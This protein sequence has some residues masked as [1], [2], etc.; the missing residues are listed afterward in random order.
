MNRLL[1]RNIVFTV[2]FLS[3]LVGLI[4]LR[5]RTPFGKDNS[6]FVSRPDEGITRIEITGGKNRLV[7]ESSEDGWIVNNNGQA[8]Q[9]AIHFINSILTTLRIKSTVSDDYFEAEIR[10]KKLEPVRVR[11]FEKRRVLSS[12]IVYKTSSNVYGNIMKISERAKP[13]IMHLPGFEGDIGSVFTI[14]ELYWKPFTIFELLPS[15]I[16]AIELGHSSDTA[17]SFRISIDKG[18]FSFYDNNGNP[19]EA[20]SVLIKRYITYFTMVPFENWAPELDEDGTRLVTGNKP[21]Y[22]LNVTTK[23]GSG[24]QL[25]LWKRNRQDGSPDTDRLWGKKTGSD[26]FF[27]VRYF[28]IDPVLKKRAYFL[29]REEDN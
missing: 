17:S 12:F 1:V 7:L 6:S 25:E 2:I 23:G 20:D 11:V 27:I 9:A 29:S 8:R 19:V 18:R 21:D 5:T 14:N 28:D 13:F 22:I 26:K 4:I 16:S 15:E 24:Y 3:L 10:E